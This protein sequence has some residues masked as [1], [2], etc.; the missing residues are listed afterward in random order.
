MKIEIQKLKQMYVFIPT[1]GFDPEYRCVF[2]VWLNKIIWYC[3]KGKK[4]E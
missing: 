4:E 2:F 1:I 3:G